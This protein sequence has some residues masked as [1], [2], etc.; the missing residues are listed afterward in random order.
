MNKIKEYGT[1]EINED[2]DYL[3]HKLILMTE[4]FEQAAA[5]VKEKGDK[6]FS[7]FHAR[8]LVEMAGNIIMGYLLLINSNTNDDYKRYA[9]IF[10]KK[11]FAENKQSLE[12]ILHSNMKDINLFKQ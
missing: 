3:K 8:R 9:E 10:I 4:D 6:E 1:E 2:V 11:V 7:D 12:Y 5:E